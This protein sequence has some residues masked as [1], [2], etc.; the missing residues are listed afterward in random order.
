MS[1]QDERQGRITDLQTHRASRTPHSRGFIAESPRPKGAEETAKPRPQL[2]MDKP[3]RLG[4]AADT[5]PS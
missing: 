3:T 1:A 2:G 5:H 4:R